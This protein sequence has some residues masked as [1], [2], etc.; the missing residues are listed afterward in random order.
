MARYQPNIEMIRKA[1]DM[2]GGLT[3][4]SKKTNISYQSVLDWK[5]GRRVPGPISCK[6]IEKATEGK[7][8]ARDILPDYPWD[9]FE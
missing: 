3:E 9:D 6:K 4:L 5:H 1:I 2:V 7:I 8:K